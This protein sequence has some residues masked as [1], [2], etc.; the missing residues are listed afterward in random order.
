MKYKKAIFLFLL[1]K[2]VE[3]PAQEFIPL[4]P[5]DHKINFNGKPVTDTIYNERM[6]RVGT[7]GIFTFKV[8]KEINKRAAVLICPGGGYERINYLFNGFN[9]ARWYNTLGI[10]AFV[11]IYRLPHQT[12]LV[13]RELA[14]LQ[15]AQRAMQIIRA[16]AVEWGI[17]KNRIGVMG[18]SAG[19]HIASSL[20]ISTEN[21]SSIGDPLDSVSFHPDF[22]VLLSP[23]ITMGK[24]AHPG[25]KRNLLGPDPTKEKMDKY[26]GELQVTATTPPTFIVHALNDSSVNVQNSVQFYTAL[27]D[28]KINA[29][30][31]VFPLGGH[32]IK[33]EDNPG[34]TEL[35]LALLEAWLREKGII[36]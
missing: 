10:N 27:L 16:S 29:S 24:Y 19:G 22:M 12:D 8:D 4:W 11:L 7:P 14:P 25:S 31:H 13:E 33:L 30:L 35:W 32:G 28:N 9:L 20:A 18:T 17:A 3:S 2:V 26:S 15:D 23:V 1:I 34:S 21:I 36:R 6:Y 5:K